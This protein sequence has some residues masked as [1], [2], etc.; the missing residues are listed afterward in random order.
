M[1]NEMTAQERKQAL[2]RSVLP[3]RT[4]A[5]RDAEATEALLER[6]MSRSVWREA[7]TILAYLA[8]P[9]EIDIDT[10]IGTA[11]ATG[12]TVAV[13]VLTKVRGV[14]EAVRLDDLT[15]VVPRTWGIREPRDV[16]AVI[17]PQTIDLVLVPGTAFG[18]D[19]ARLG[20]GGGYYDRYLPQTDAFRLGIAAEC[21]LTEDIPMT[22]TDAVMDAVVTEAAWYTPREG[23]ERRK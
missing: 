13:P 14:M 21:M 8:M 6:L 16:T 18:K 3:L 4:E 10:L 20:A 15:A 22:A 1:T 17:A 12:K 19:G 23:A 7:K 9:T 11:L 2:R 5:A